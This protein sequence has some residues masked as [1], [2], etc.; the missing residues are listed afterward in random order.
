MSN[1]NDMLF[2][3]ED[4][5]IID[6][7]Y[8]KT[9]K[10]KK[11]KDDKCNVLIID[12][13]IGNLEV[14][15]KFLQNHYN[16]FSCI[17]PLKAVNLLQAHDFFVIICDQRMPE[18]QGTEFFKIAK[19]IQPF[20]TRIILTGYS[21]AGDIIESINSGQ[22]YRYILKPWEEDLSQTVR[23]AIEKSELQRMNFELMQKLQEA[24]KELE[25]RFSIVLESG[26][27][28]LLLLKK[29]DF[30]IYSSNDLFC[31]M[32]DYSLE[33]LYGLTLNHLCDEKDFA[34]VKNSLDSLDKGEIF[35]AEDLPIKKKDG[36]IFYAEATSSH[37]NIT[38]ETLLMYIFR[39]ITDRKLM[40]D[41]LFK[42]KEKAEAANRAKSEFLSNMSHEIRTPLNSIIGM[43]ELLSQSELSE[44]Q[45]KYTKIFKS[46][47]EDLLTTIN[48][49]LDLS[50]VEC[51]RLELEN[52]EFNLYDHIDKAFE[53]LVIKA[54]E[55]GLKLNRNINSVVPNNLVGDPV[56]L[57]Q[58]IVNL[59]SNAIKF[60]H[61]G[62]I[63]LQVEI[64]DINNESQDSLNQK[65]NNKVS[66]LFSV[67][68]TGIGISNEKIETIFESFSQADTS[69]TREY[70]GTGLGL[71]I[72]K[73][74]IELMKGKI[75]VESS[76]NKGS[77]FYFEISFE[78]GKIGKK[79]KSIETDILKNTKTLIVYD[80]PSNRFIL[81]EII[82]DY[83]GEILEASNENECIELLENSN[84]STKPINILILYARMTNMSGF[85]ILSS[86]NKRV[87]RNWCGQI[88]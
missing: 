25:E 79:L 36:T 87:N 85:D 35:V 59:I 19:E 81:K 39:D 31:K 83:G 10:N 7:V 67:S 50:K 27:D 75:W 84:K 33:E 3:D 62:K 49:I 51:G 54:Q 76:L 46:A 44:E 65:N 56:R 45:Y 57:K 77:I 86:I 53:I 78:K 68:D 6:E 9:S 23:N 18:M 4:F 40:Q 80:D 63:D 64:K 58:I 13:E 17:D 30:S 21:D 32:V 70:G 55:K 16:V 60:T 12:D 61:M 66:L 8:E 71:S 73:R 14:L 37:L 72:T 15:K 29:D 42:A 20:A 43:A 88:L 41:D 69:I 22:V 74:L 82:S 26:G 28:G 34:Y 47:G 24:N 38:G 52:I 1:D 11:N 48:E 5:N 2:Q